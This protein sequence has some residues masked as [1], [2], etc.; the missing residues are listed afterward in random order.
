MNSGQRAAKGLPA[1]LRLP[2]FATAVA[3]L[4]LV[5]AAPAPATP[6]IAP[7][8]EPATAAGLPAAP[9]ESL[10]WAGTVL[11]PPIEPGYRP[12]GDGSL[13]GPAHLDG[14]A[15]PQSG[16]VLLAL[17]AAITAAALARFGRAGRFRRLSARSAGSGRIGEDAN[18][19]MATVERQRRELDRHRAAIGALQNQAARALAASAAKS[20]FLADMSHE[21]RTPLNA[22]IGFSE[23][24]RTESLGPIGN[25]T[26]RSYVDDINFCGRHLLAVIND[27]LDIVRHD[28][29]KLELKEEPVA[30]EAA[31][32][33]ACR[34]VAPQALRACVTLARPPPGIDL[35]TLYCDRLR[36]RQILSNILSNAVKF[37]EPGGRI[38]I[39]IDVSD[40][41]AVV[42]KDTGIGIEPQDIPVVLSRFGQA[43]P[44][45]SHD[46]PGA[47]LG[48]TLAK[49]L[50]EQHGGTL[51]LESTPQVGTIVRICFPQGRVAAS[52]AGDRGGRVR[53]G[54]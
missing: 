45:G 12:S 49:A 30:I 48:L 40:G 4:T 13:V 15:Q 37:S 11:S 36:L 7:E 50:I 26:Y 27:V 51:L 1:R 8:H 31:I 14:L 18:E 29:G 38:D 43:A 22:I 35:P 34:L 33:E 6:L 28:A 20:D 16:L 52:D 54:F 23:I 39:A 53:P 42:V 17:S 10:G 2:A 44:A 5:A 25:Q 47:G 3:A 9:R 21:L 19:T 46:S 41:L 24:I 32:E